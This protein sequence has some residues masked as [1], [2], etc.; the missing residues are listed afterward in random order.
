ML[1]SLQIIKDI[2]HSHPSQRVTISWIKSTNRSTLIHNK[3]W[4]IY[5]H[6][7]T[8]VTSY[9]GLPNCKELYCLK[10][11]LRYTYFSTSE[12]HSI[13]DIDLLSRM[14]NITQITT[15]IRTQWRQ[16]IREQYSID[17]TR[18]PFLQPFLYK[19]GESKRC[20]YFS[21]SWPNNQF[22]E[23]TKLERLLQY[24]TSQKLST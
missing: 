23:N 6:C 4:N 9:K 17:K 24:D 14:G 19:I 8:R 3:I 20:H 11:T 18:L 2:K 7:E 13:A 1:I 10:Y 12:H 15:K 22:E 16:S 21:S 5:E